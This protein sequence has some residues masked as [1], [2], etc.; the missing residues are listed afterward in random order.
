[1]ALNNCTREIVKGIVA[2]SF[3]CLDE[4]VKEAVQPPNSKVVR[5]RFTKTMVS[6]Y[7]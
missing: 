4:K 6:C 1:M 3:L 2:D 7:K 5:P